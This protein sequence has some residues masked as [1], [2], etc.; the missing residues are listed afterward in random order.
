[1]C[2][3]EDSS[4]EMYYT[5]RNSIIRSINYDFGTARDMGDYSNA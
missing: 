2:L 5:P 4:N 3:H 1:M